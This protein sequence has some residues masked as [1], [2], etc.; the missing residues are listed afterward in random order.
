MG[1]DPTHHRT[2]PRGD[3]NDD[4]ED[5]NAHNELELSRADQ[6]SEPPNELGAAGVDAS[7][8]GFLLSRRVD[9]AVHVG[10]GHGCGHRTGRPGVADA[11]D[12]GH[13]IEFN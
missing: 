9:S 7:G 4:G 8:G 2:K 6:A 10:C 3:Q 5:D 12:R 11:N 13:W 1:R